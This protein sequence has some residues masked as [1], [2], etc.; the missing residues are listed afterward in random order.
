MNNQEI[1]NALKQLGTFAF[2]FMVARGYLT[3]DQSTALLNDL[4]VII[5]AIGGLCTM[6]W[7]I[8]SHWNMKKVPQNSTAIGTTTAMPVGST[9]PAALAVATKVV[10]TLLI[11]FLALQAL[12]PAH[13]VAATRHHH[14]VAQVAAQA[15]PLPSPRPLYDSAT[16]PTP[17]LTT[18]QVQQNPLVLFQ[19]I[20]TSDL[21]A[22][23]TDAQA[24]TPP[25]SVA[26]SCY[27]AL[28]NLKNNPAF[29]LP[30]GQVIG[31][32]M[33]IQK[34][35]DL[36]VMLANLASPNGP[37][38]GLNAACAAWTQDNVATLIAVGG[39]VGLVANPAGAVAAAGGAA[40]A[41][42]AQI[43]AFLALLPK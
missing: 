34:G 24:Q 5:P 12:A 28:L 2:A 42:N 20:A 3:H 23:L 35:R 4:S 27:Q 18:E 8:Y 6:G 41:F 14:A 43:L 21:T 32:F 40:A 7:S 38:A 13:A 22:A 19:N 33:A 25:D 10:G 16:A 29:A 37:L 9:M 30:S 17:K 39:A 11:G 26:A 15:V 31:P 1:L 36:K